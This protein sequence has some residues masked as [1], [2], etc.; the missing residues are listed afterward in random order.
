MHIKTLIVSGHPLKPET[1]NERWEYFKKR[2]G[3]ID[4]FFGSGDFTRENVPIVFTFS[5]S[6]IS[7]SFEIKFDSKIELSNFIKE[8]NT[9]NDRNNDQEMC[10]ILQYGEG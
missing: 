4:H 9:A 8:M 3:C 10:Q 7:A 5:V 2:N 6:K 1:I